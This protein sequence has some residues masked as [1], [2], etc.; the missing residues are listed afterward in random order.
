MAVSGVKEHYGNTPGRPCTV[1]WGFEILRERGALVKEIRLI[2][3]R[4]MTTT[5]PREFL[6]A[7]ESLMNFC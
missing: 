1:L 6:F 5:R 2:A 4:L 3:K 7:H